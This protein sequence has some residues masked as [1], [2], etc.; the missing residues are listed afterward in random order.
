MPKHLFLACLLYI[1]ARG[2]MAVL[3]PLY[4]K[5]IPQFTSP[6]LMLLFIGI[7]VLFMRRVQWTWKL[8]QSIAVTE[9]GINALFFPES[10]FH[11]AYTDIV[12]MLITVVMLASCVILWSL[13]RR[14][15]AKA[16]FVRS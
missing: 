2:A 8:M 3:A 15:E 13:M 10:K 6:V 7:A 9:I 4:E 1:S 14:P 16:W 11:G 12:R 5:G